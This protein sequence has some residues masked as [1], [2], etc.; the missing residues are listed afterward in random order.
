MDTTF[1]QT[2][3]GVGL[4]ALYLYAPVPRGYRGGAFLLLFLLFPLVAGS[5]VRDLR[6]A[7]HGVSTTGTALTAHCTGGKNQQMI[8]SYRF[9][10]DGVTMTATGPAGEGNG[11]CDMR[12]GDTVYLSY[13]PKEPVVSA[14]VRHP[15]R[16]LLEQLIGWLAACLFLT[17]LKTEQ[18][19]RVRAHFDTLAFRRP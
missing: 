8:L 7:W 4:L 1:L 19:A 15:A 13:L 18:A 16:S 9:V 11:G 2:L 6:L 10:A 17:W 3:I 14:A 12:A 5:P